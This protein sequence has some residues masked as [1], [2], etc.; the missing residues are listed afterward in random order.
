MLLVPTSMVKEMDEGNVF[1]AA[2]RRLL[3]GF[4]AVK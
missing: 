3:F 2:R 4:S 1:A